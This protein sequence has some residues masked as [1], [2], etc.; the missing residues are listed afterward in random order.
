M[1]R[2]YGVM[3]DANSLIQHFNP[4]CRA[5]RLF[6]HL[7]VARFLISV[8][9]YDIPKFTVD[10]SHHS[11]SEPFATLMRINI[12]LVAFLTQL[13]FSVQDSIVDILGTVFINVIAIG[14]FLLGNAV[15]GAAIAVVV[16]ILIA[17]WLR[18]TQ[19]LNS[20]RKKKTSLNFKKYIPAPSPV[21]VVPV[22]AVSKINDDFD[23]KVLFKS[24]FKALDEHEA[25]RLGSSTPRQIDEADR[26]MS[27][28]LY[29]KSAIKSNESGAHRGRSALSL[30]PNPSPTLAYL[31]NESVASVGGSVHSRAS[32]GAVGSGFSRAGSSGSIPAAPTVEMH[33]PSPV[34]H[35]SKSMR[36]DPIPAQVSAVAPTKQPTRSV[37]TPLTL[38]ELH[39]MEMGTDEEV[40]KA[41][42]KALRRAAKKSKK[43]ASR[44][45]HHDDSGLGVQD[46]GRAAGV[47]PT[48]LSEDD[49]FSHATETSEQRDA[50]RRYKRRKDR[51]GHK[52]SD[53]GGP[54]ISSA[55]KLHDTAVNEMSGEDKPSAGV[56]FDPNMSIMSGNA[57]GAFAAKSSMMQSSRTSQF[58]TWH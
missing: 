26:M 55:R 49:N 40:E 14:L 41:E 18:E 35:H 16:V 44:M 15:L 51:F 4:A 13:P 23:K 56:N 32:R 17:I 43:R 36:A 2:R 21:R 46:S 27:S 30:S 22:D 31:P 45:H 7:P 6:P 52:E 48:K 50:R 57:P 11:M 19:F 8:N 5:A 28:A 54:G 1:N 58:P 10:P 38:Q 24:Q 39:N 29:P 47:S 37:M 25:M 9:D 53:T 34:V 42:L 3:R 33:K 12:A 20:L